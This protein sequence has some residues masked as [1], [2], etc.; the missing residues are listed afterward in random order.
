[1]TPIAWVFAFTVYATAVVF[2]IVLLRRPAP[3]KPLDRDALEA[4]D[5]ALRG[6]LTELEDR[7]DR[8]VK[9]DAVRAGRE[10]ADEA[11]Q[12][13]LPLDRAGRLSLLRQKALA[14]KQ[15]G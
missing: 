5:A 1:M 7:F 10:K 2:A 6:R 3:K 15:G 9:R 8:H 12:G 4:T 11:A 13:T 14:L